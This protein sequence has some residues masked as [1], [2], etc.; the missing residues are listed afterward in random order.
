M[1]FPPMMSIQ[2]NVAGVDMYLQRTGG[3]FGEMKTPGE[4][5]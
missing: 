4:P 5:V 1:A 3:S 2:L